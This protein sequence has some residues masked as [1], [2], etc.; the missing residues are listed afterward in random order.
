MTDINT[1]HSAKNSRILIVDDSPK[2]VEILQNFL[3]KNGYQVLTA[4]DGVQAFEMCKV[5]LP[6]LILLD[7]IMPKM[8]GYETCASLKKEETTKDIP[9]IFLSSLT[10]INDLI[11]GFQYGAV[12]YITKPFNSHEILVR[13]K[14]QLDLKNSKETIQIQKKNYQQLVN[15]LCHDITNP[16]NTI[17][18]LV[19]FL[20]SN[21]NNINKMLE[22]IE[23]AAQN[24]LG[25]INM[26]RENIAIEEGKR[27][28]K[29][30][31]SNLRYLL[32]ISIGLIRREFSKKNIKLNI[33]IDPDYYVLVENTSFVNSV[34]NNIFTNAIKF[35][36]SG[37][38]IDVTAT[39]DGY[40][41]Y[42]KVQDQGIGIPPKLLD[43]LFDMTQQTHRAGTDGEPGT[44]FGMPLAYRFMQYYGGSIEV[45]SVDKRENP[46]EHGTTVILKLLKTEGAKQ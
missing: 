12:D 27:K 43:N 14:T 4:F 46:T 13:I 37:Q 19:D 10:D 32:N 2:N 23:K 26:V 30:R 6:D 7:I 24:G 29:L 44:G 40:W 3:H 20:K 9:V 35:S 36:T 18:T 17:T 1:E 39:E 15:V 5:H 31:S 21:K 25:I 45:Q 34:L 8:N 42:L 16:F 11:Q 22:T 33:E 38:N 28:L 41:I